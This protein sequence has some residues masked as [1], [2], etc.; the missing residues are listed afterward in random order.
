M[1][2]RGGECRVA[3]AGYAGEEYVAMPRQQLKSNVSRAK[4]KYSALDDEKRRTEEN[5][6]DIGLQTPMG[7]VQERVGGRI[8]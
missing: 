5:S 2:W 7:N 4:E 1:E 6:F 3:K 8:D